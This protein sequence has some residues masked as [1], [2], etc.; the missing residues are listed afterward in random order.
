[1]WPT[2][3]AYRKDVHDHHMAQV[4]CILDVKPYLDRYHSLKWYISGFN[5]AIKC[6]YI[7]N[8]IAEVFNNLIKDM[9]DLPVCELANKLR[10]RIMILW[11]NRRMIGQRLDGKIQPA[12]LHVLKT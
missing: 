5:S 12:I 11:H 2:T 7:T 1:M 9:K 3:R 6:D 4:Y 10:E 8:N